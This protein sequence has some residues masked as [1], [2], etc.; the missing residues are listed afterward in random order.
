[1]AVKRF[2]NIVLDKSKAVMLDNGMMRVPARIGRVGIQ[3][4]RKADGSIE[5]AYRPAEEVFAEDAM[6]S[7]DLMPLTNEH[8]YK[9]GGVVT[10]QNAQ[11][12]VKGSL[13]NIRREDD[14]LMADV[15]I[16]AQ[17]A[18]DAVKAGRQEVSSG[19]FT[20]KDY[21]PGVFNGQKYDF[22]QR[23]IRGN[24]AAIVD[25]GRAGPDVRLQLDSSAAVEVTASENQGTSPNEEKPEMEK[26]VIDGLEVEVTPIAAK[27]IAKRDAF[28]ASQVAQSEKALAETKA[29]LDRK[30]AQCDQADAKIA[31]LEAEL[32][33]APAKVRAELTER[34]ALEA[35]AKT[36]GAE[37]KAD[38]SQDEIKR[39]VVSKLSPSLKLDGQSADYVS[40][41]FDFAMAD[42]EKKNPATEKVQ[43]ALDAANAPKTVNDKA[44]DPQ[45]QM[46]K[47]FFS[48]K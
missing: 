17:D 26:I 31:K 16:Y 44:E 3:L 23:T 19:Y 33:E 46:L 41:A 47:D 30:T 20:E 38:A 37:F 29:N 11:R 35:R 5:R 36:T 40:A 25:T 39:A 13:G 18:I 10:S 9:D 21:T 43:A 12:L 28:V 32:K 2:D 15:I 8:P 24:H 42:H 22:V 4:Y 48:K 34:V 27:V 6:K 45:E 14:Y 7:F 1:M